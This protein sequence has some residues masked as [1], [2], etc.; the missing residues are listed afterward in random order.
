MAH[1]SYSIP[2]LREAI[3]SLDSKM[4][5]LM[6]QRRQLECNLERAVRSQSPV[7]R[8][9]SELLSCIFI[10]GV[11]GMGDENPVMVATLMLVW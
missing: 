11:F 4:A 7:L 1:S 5:Y 10:I 3:N 2:R 9:P 6:S 8:L